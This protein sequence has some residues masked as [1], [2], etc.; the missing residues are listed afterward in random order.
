MKTFMLWL[1]LYAVPAFL[2]LV[3]I[4]VYAGAVSLEIFG[5]SIGQGVHCLNFSGTIAPGRFW[6]WGWRE[7]LGKLRGSDTGKSTKKS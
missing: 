7:C 4:T 1:A 5:A 6:Q 3:L 2:I